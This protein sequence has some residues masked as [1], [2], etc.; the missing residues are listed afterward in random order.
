MIGKLPGMNDSWATPG[1]GT[2]RREVAPGDVVLFTMP[3]HPLNPNRRVARPALVVNDAGA[4]TGIRGKVLDLWV[5]PA[6]DDQWLVHKDADIRTAWLEGDG[7][8][9]AR[10]VAFPFYVTGAQRSVNELAPGCWH[11]PEDPVAKGIVRVID[12][13][14]QETLRDHLAYL[15]TP[16]TPVDHPAADT[17]HLRGRECEHQGNLQMALALYELALELDPGWP[18]AVNAIDRVRRKLYTA[19]GVAP[20]DTDTDTDTTDIKSEKE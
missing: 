12:H 10:R 20:A 18:D 1:P 7:P 4:P 17:A 16:G 13:G 6:P 5:F 2:A 8:N 11:L 3:V 19:S 15:A 14:P 9:G